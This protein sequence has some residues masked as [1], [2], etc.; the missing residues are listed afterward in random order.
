[1]NKLASIFFLHELGLPTV[2][3]RIIFSRD[4]KG[5]RREVD[6]FYY[7]YTDG[8]ALRCGELP[9]KDS[10]AE[11]QM[12]WGMAHGKKELVRKIIAL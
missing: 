10:K 5:I 8:W 6:N 7:E 12:P 3:P 1:M 4:E 2:F 11:V 9:D